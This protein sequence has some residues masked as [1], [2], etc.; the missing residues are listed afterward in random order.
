MQPARAWLAAWARASANSSAAATARREGFSDIG[1][2][3]ESVSRLRVAHG[4]RLA[5]LRE[6]NSD[7]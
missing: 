6:E 3:F 7:G 4:A 1:S 5:A 2:W